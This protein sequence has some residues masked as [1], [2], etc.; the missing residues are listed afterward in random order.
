MGSRTVLFA[1]IF[2]FCSCGALFLP[3][4]GLLGYMAHYIIGPEGQWWTAPLRQFEIRYSLTLAVMAALGIALN[5]QKLRYGASLLTFH[6]KILLAFVGL[7]WLLQAVSEPTVY[8]PLL[9]HPSLKLTKVAIFCLMLTHVVTDG[10]SLKIL[11]WILVLS[12][13]ILGIE[14]YAT[15]RWMF[16]S[17]RLE[18]V[19]GVDFNE[20]NFLP[21][22][23]GGV[24]PLMGILFLE[25][26]WLGKLAALAAGVFSVNA[27]VLT[28]SRG[29]MV[30]I[31]LGGLASLMLAPKGYRMKIF[32]G[33]LVAGMGGLYL[34]DATFLSRVATIDRDD[35]QRDR[36]AQSRLEIW[37]LSFRMVSDY[38][39]GVGAGNF[40]QFAGHYNSKF[41]GRD[42]HNTYVRCFTELGIPGF[43]L[44][45]GLIANA[46]VVSK[47]TIRKAYDLPPEY[48]S[49]I[50]MPSFGIAVGLCMM[51][52]C[53]VTVTLL[54][55]EALWWFLL[56]PVCVERAADNL[57]A[58]CARESQMI[59]EEGV[60]D[61]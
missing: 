4:L 2:L 32:A 44:F 49:Q 28:R 24:L 19:G 52:G 8:N 22:F 48:R 35:E 56:M 25:S 39:L 60:L 26:R 29:A 15:P 20:A 13:F 23:I 6:E 9:D 46:I 59:L 10:K 42:A 55:T 43:L 61:E 21:A 51:L 50:L 27:I 36:S 47:R 57:A 54:Y 7:L 37:A 45:V 58:D 11:L 1:A 31:A 18:G 3:L 41:E 17:G 38:P 16:A 33:L 14:A 34:T 53:G 40:A 30:G 5:S 12:T